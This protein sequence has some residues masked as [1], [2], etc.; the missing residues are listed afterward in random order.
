MPMSSG[1]QA[2]FPTSWLHLR[3][4]AAMRFNLFPIDR[5]KPPAWYVVQNRPGEFDKTHRELVR[6]LG[7]KHVLVAK[8]GVPLVWAFPYDEVER[9]LKAAATPRGPA[10]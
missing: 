4:V 6:T 8:F 5:R 7:P 1:E 2:T 9:A 10:P 3:N